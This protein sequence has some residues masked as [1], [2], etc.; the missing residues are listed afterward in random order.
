MN[1]E[2][3]LKETVIALRK[4]LLEAQK[5]AAGQDL[6]FKI[7]E[8][9]LELELVTSKEGEGGRGVKFWVYNAQMKAKLGKTRTHRLCLKLKPETQ[10]GD[11]R[12]A[13][14]DTK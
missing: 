6:K 13:D 7:E 11:T 9:E 12:I 5:E 2:I 14:R 3:G 10:G 4:E 1:E 8:I